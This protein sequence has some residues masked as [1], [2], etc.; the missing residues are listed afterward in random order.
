[1]GPNSSCEI[2]ID[3]CCSTLGTQIYCGRTTVKLLNIRAPEKLAVIN[4]KF[5]QWLY[6]RVMRP[7]DTDGMANSVDPDETDPNGKQCRPR[8]DDC[9]SWSSLI[10]VYTVCPGLSVR[11]LRN[12]M[13]GLVWPS[14]SIIC[15]DDAT[16]LVSGPWHFSDTTSYRWTLNS[17]PQPDNAGI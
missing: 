11:K 1:M 15:L 4:L 10:W 3:T 8:S 6:H 16:F 14:V 7:K 9:S 13:I 12:F 5:E 2:N 17:M